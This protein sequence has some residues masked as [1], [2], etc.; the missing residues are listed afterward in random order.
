MP[1]LKA[2]IPSLFG[3]RKAAGA[4]REICTSDRDRTLSL[5]RHDNATAYSL[6]RDVAFVDL[7][8]RPL[9]TATRASTLPRATAIV[10]EGKAR[11]RT[12]SSITGDRLQAGRRHHPRRQS[13]DLAP[14]RESRTQR[15]QKSRRNERRQGQ[16][17]IALLWRMPYR[18]GDRREARQHATDIPSERAGCKRP[19]L[20][21]E[22]ASRSCVL[23][24]DQHAFPRT[25]CLARRKQRQRA[26]EHCAADAL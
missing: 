7:D 18:A 20:S 26:S 3:R 16:G 5:G 22:R 6:C 12:R 1:A 21:C 19:N 15:D 23:Q 24:Y 13:R 11:C 14:C 4:P 25:S 9:C 17:R 10:R 2:E 8:R